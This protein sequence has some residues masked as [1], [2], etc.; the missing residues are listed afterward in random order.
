MS[1]RAA[2]E[3]TIPVQRVAGGV[4]R[5]AVRTPRCHSHAHARAPSTPP[6]S[7]MPTPMQGA[8]HHTP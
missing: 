4:A 3:A 5:W 1:K 8:W 2:H 6:L 7:P